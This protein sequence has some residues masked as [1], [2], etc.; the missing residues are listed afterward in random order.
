MYVSIISKADNFYAP[1]PIMPPAPPPPDFLRES[2]SEV[3]TFIV[4]IICYLF[5]GGGWILDK[6]NEFQFYEAG[7]R[8][9]PPVLIWISISFKVNCIQ[10]F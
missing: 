9:I 3:I 6:Q 7:W 8:H 2:F 5:T 4:I 1:P 10:L